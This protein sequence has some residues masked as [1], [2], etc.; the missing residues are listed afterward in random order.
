[1]EAVVDLSIKV[2]GM[3]VKKIHLL[4]V[5]KHSPEVIPY[6]IFLKFSPLKPELIGVYFN[7]FM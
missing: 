5:S 1:M 4:S 2:G 6:H 7:I 3:Q